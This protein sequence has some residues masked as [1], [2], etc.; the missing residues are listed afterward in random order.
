MGKK[1]GTLSYLIRGKRSPPPT[2]YESTDYTKKGGGG[3]EKSISSFLSH[4]EK[5][6][7]RRMGHLPFG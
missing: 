2:L 4:K 1:R 7:R 5:I 6:R 3:R